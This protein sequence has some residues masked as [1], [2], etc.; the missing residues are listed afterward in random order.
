MLTYSTYNLAF[1]FFFSHLA[2]DNI[3]VKHQVLYNYL[4]LI[5]VIF[6]HSQ[7]IFSSLHWR[8]EQYRFELIVLSLLRV[9]MLLLRQN[10]SYFTLN[11]I[12]KKYDT[13]NS[14]H[15]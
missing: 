4:R 9:L 3:H 15:R 13:I 11:K 2:H 14:G 5:Y 8:I 1:E 6:L 7:L 12:E 10:F